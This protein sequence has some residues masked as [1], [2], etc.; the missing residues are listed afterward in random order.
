MR[1]DAELSCVALLTYYADAELA[2]A[3][4]DVCRSRRRRRKLRSLR[5]VVA[6]PPNRKVGYTEHV[7]DIM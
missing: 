3:D 1:L 4:A 2:R 7:H 6:K 5:A